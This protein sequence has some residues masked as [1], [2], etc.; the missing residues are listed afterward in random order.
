MDILGWLCL[1]LC[2]LGLEPQP[3]HPKICQ[4]LRRHPG[5]LAR[6]MKGKHRREGVTERDEMSPVSAQAHFSPPPPDF[7]GCHRWER[8][9]LHTGRAV[10]STDTGTVCDKLQ[11]PEPQEPGARPARPPTPCSAL[12][13]EHR[14]SW[15]P[16]E[17]A[18]GAETARPAG[19]AQAGRAARPLGRFGHVSSSLCLT[20]LHAVHSLCHSAKVHRTPRPRSILGAQDEACHPHACWVC[21]GNLG[22]RAAGTRRRGRT[23]VRTP[24]GL[25]PRGRA[26]EGHGPTGHM[27]GRSRSAPGGDDHSRRPLL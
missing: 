4:L 15:A 8:A 27:D 25:Q 17:Q 19:R 21:S 16:P 1:G 24:F 18:Q 14:A 7:I 26:G 22:P 23:A 2:H 13:S 11:E 10:G 20:L 12:A 3:G 6:S 9:H 5:T